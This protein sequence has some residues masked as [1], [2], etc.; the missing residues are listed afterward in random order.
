MSNKA[1]QDFGFLPFPWV[2]V[3]KKKAECKGK[4]SSRQRIYYPY[5]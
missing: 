5:S 3:S 4:L 1:R 2:Y